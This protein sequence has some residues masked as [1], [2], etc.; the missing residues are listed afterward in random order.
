MIKMVPFTIDSQASIIGNFPNNWTHYDVTREPMLFNCTREFAYTF[1]GPITKAC[2]DNLPKDWQSCQIVIESL[3]H[4]LKLGWYPYVSG[5]HCDDRVGYTKLNSELVKGIP[6][7]FLQ[8]DRAKNDHIIALINAD[9]SPTEFAIGKHEVE[10]PEFDEK[11]YDSLVELMKLKTNTPE[12]CDKRWPIWHLHFK[13]QN[14]VN[15]NIMKKINAPNASYVQYDDK[16]FHKTVPATT[17]GYRWFIRISRSKDGK[18]YSNH[19]YTNELR[20]SSHVYI[21][22]PDLD[23]IESYANMKNKK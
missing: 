19:E 17:N 9:I 16:T 8:S 4:K 5:Y 15:K 22:F 18:E 21:N 13:V 1:G 2:L 23:V 6:A 14:L 3:V 7:S 10:V 11:H 12:T 20:H